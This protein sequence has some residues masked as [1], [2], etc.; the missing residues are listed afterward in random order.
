MLC[1]SADDQ[2]YL[3]NASDALQKG[4]YAEVFSNIEN[5]ISIN[6]K[7][8]N[9][10]RIRLMAYTFTKDYIPALKDA[11]KLIELDPK[12]SKAYWLRGVIRTEL[13]NI[14]GAIEDF[15]KSIE[16]NPKN[17]S[18]YFARAK[19]KN[20]IADYKGAIKDCDYALKLD[21]SEAMAYYYR[22][23]AEFG[24]NK[25]NE[26]IVDYDQ[27]IELMPNDNQAYFDRG[28]TKFY[29]SDPVGAFED[30]RKSNELGNID[31]YKKINELDSD[32]LS[33]TERNKMELNGLINNATY[34]SLIQNLGT[35]IST[36]DGIDVFIAD[37][38][39]FEP[40]LRIIF[41]NASKIRFVFDKKNHTVKSWTITY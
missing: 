16:L 25:Y 17:S 6:S 23:N 30:L 40:A 39:N 20:T 4:N 19:A 29:N 37:F 11:N 27:T 9:S 34:D 15:N 38:S 26:A 32:A 8:P 41:G 35:P 28:V 5:A 2:I 14:K 33:A 3:E 31:A 18:V 36:T 10:Y 1:Y 24:L 13:K 22:G 7:N 21:P 12:D